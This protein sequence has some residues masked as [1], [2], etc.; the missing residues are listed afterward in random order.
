M[1]ETDIRPE[2]LLNRYLELSAQDADR[3]FNGVLKDD[4]PCVACG[5]DRSEFQFNKNGFDYSLCL[6]CSTLYL[7]PRPKI[8]S[9]ESFY[10]NSKSSQYWADVFFPAVA[11]ARR[12]QIFRPRVERLSHLC[13]TRGILV[14]KII[15]V[16]A[17]YGIFLDEWRKLNPLLKSIAIE[18]SVTLATECRNKGFEVNENIVENVTGYDNFADLV[19]CFEVLEHVYDPLH[20]VQTLSKLTKPGGYVFLSTLCVDGFDIQVLWEKSKSI[21]PPHHIN[22]LSVKGFYELFKRAGLVDVDVSTPGQLDV[23]IVRNMTMNNSHLLRNDRFLQHLIE[24]ENLS[25]SFQKFLADNRLSSHAWIIGRKP[26][27]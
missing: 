10:R 18:P 11:E 20:F 16:G 4:F 17:G 1:K 3:C 19:V 5:N 26:L 2:A 9:F 24:D 21:F 13:R 12:E 8:E 22:F 14:E 6:Y 23:D 7:S 15:D 27:H 25:I